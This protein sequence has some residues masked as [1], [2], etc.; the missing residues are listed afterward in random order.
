MLVFLLEGR[1]ADHEDNDTGMRRLDTEE[2]SQDSPKSSP[3]KR[4]PRTHRANSDEPSIGMSQTVAAGSTVTL[5]VDA[6]AGSWGAAVFHREPVYIENI[7]E[8]PQWADFA[9]FAERFSLRACWST[10]IRRAPPPAG[11]RNVPT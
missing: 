7:A 10:P 2:S 8:S 6:A 11:A 1:P 9:D 4:R 3:K 5:A